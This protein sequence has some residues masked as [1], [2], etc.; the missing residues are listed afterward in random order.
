MAV[1]TVVYTV[2]SSFSKHD[3]RDFGPE[4]ATFGRIPEKFHSIN[5]C[6]AIILTS[7]ETDTRVFRCFS[8]IFL[9]PMRPWKTDFG[10]IRLFYHW[11]SS[12]CNPGPEG[13]TFWLISENVHSINFC[14][15][16]ILASLKAVKR[17]F[18]CVSLF[19]SLL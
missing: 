15:A 10:K 9:H 14:S 13:A 18:R 6:S 19:F 5:F 7:L 11:E 3:F 12:F 2:V 17:V 1:Y 8:V 4:G 16:I